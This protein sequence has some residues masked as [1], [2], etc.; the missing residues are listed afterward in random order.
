MTTDESQ[1]TRQIVM[2]KL[3]LTMTDATISEWLKQDGDYVRQGD[4]LFV[5]ES[6]KA[7]LEFEAPASGTLRILV[8]AGETVPVMTP[9]AFLGTGEPTEAHPVR[10]A[11]PPSQPVTAVPLQGTADAPQDGRVKASPKARITARREGLSLENLTGT[12]PR[13]MIVTADLEQARR[14]S[15]PRATVQASPLAQRMAADL[16]VDLASVNGTGPDGRITRA[17]VAEAVRTAMTGQ[18]QAPAP[19]GPDLSGLEGLRGVIAQRLSQGWH[20][21]PQV[22]L[23]TDAD[24]TNLVAARQQAMDELGEK[25]AYDALLVML[26]A[27]ALR[28][29]PAMNSQLT[30]DGIIHQPQ[31]NIGVAVDTERGL[32]VP[33][34]READRLTLAALNRSVRDSAHRAVEGTSQPD[35]LAGGTFTLT[36]LGMFGIDAFTPII[37]PPECCILGVGRIVSRPVGMDGQI[38]LRDMMALS[39]SFDHRLVDGAPAARFLQ[40]VKTLIERPFTLALLS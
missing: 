15:S 39:L 16:G 28:E 32:M 13:G 22:T 17:D 35:E 3:G 21:R 38:V 7:M 29:H 30:P 26:V 25:I 31:I 33:V 6:E 37:N 4:V 27:R 10:A 19:D 23:T 1:T 14:A 5:F 8:Q 34:I 12:G 36:N 24:A 40:R 11:V 20:G 18:A 9:V 2:P